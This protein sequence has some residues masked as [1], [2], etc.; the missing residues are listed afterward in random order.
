MTVMVL[1]KVFIWEL[2]S[3]HSDVCNFPSEVLSATD[4]AQYSLFWD[5]NKSGYNSPMG[6]DNLEAITVNLREPLRLISDLSIMCKRKP[7][8]YKIA[9]VQPVTSLT[10]MVSGFL[11]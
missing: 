6:M 7:I 8:R 5:W 2:G 9:K 10:F 1:L 4:F 11:L 3:V